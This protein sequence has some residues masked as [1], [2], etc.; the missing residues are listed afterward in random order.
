LPAIGDALVEVSFEKIHAWDSREID[1]PRSEGKC[2][3]PASEVGH[4]CAEP[5]TAIDDA[6]SDVPS[7][8]IQASDSRDIDEPRSEAK[9]ALPASEVG[10][11]DAKSEA[12]SQKLQALDSRENDEPRSEAKFPLPASQGDS[13]PGPLTALEKEFLIEQLQEEEN[14]LRHLLQGPD[15]GETTSSEVKCT[16]QSL[17]E[18]CTQ[19]SSNEEETFHIGEFVEFEY[20]EQWKKGVV[21]SIVPLMVRYAVLH[22]DEGLAYENVRKMAQA[23]STQEKNVLKKPDDKKSEERRS[24]LESDEKI[25]NVLFTES[26]LV[27]T[28]ES[29]GEKLEQMPQQA[30]N[31]EVDE[32][33]LKA[34]QS[35]FSCVTACDRLMTELGNAKGDDLPA[36]PVATSK[37]GS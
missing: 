11:D 21:T 17:E 15:D 14:F 34:K 2:A 29:C 37:G 22:D 26:A 33:N 28:N 13:C 35:L 32:A 36:R 25:E 31:V 16:L 24:L 7:E 9:C 23:N 3:L 8:K 1:E 18:E 30:D 12:P 20:D 27:E 5:L 6:K 10:H 19:Q 4:S